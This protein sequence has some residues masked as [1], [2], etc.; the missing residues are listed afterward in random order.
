MSSSLPQ[1]PAINIFSTPYMHH[2]A[3]Y[4]DG[5]TGENALLIPVFRV[6]PISSLVTRRGVLNLGLVTRL[7]CYLTVPI[8]EVI[9]EDKRAREG[10]KPKCPQC[11]G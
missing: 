5:R 9:A 3:F 8:G 7:M 10:R 11:N 6:A 2:S 1:L 4:V